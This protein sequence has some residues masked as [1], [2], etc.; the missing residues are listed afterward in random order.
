MDKNNN[1]HDTVRPQDAPNNHVQ[2]TNGE[3]IEDLDFLTSLISQLEDDDEISV[4]INQSNG[5]APLVE[6]EDF[7]KVDIDVTDEEEDTYEDNSN[8]NLFDVL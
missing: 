2:V 1:T 7:G 4:T 6:E 5:S 3:E 8:S